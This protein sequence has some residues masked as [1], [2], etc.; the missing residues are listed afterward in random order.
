VEDDPLP[1]TTR[2]PLSDLG[3]FDLLLPA[4]GTPFRAEIDIAVKPSGVRL[5]A[6]AELDGVR[7]L[8][9]LT[10]EGYGPAILPATA[11]PPHLRPRFRLIGIDDL[12]PR[13]VVL[14]QRTRGMPSAAARAVADTLRQVVGTPGRLPEGVHAVVPD[15]SARSEGSLRIVGMPNG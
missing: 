15:A 13:R 11:V 6:R 5:R 9:S 1:G 10:F 8:A 4:P 3:R 14:A 7:L 2:I 12:P